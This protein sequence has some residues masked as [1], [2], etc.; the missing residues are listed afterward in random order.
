MSTVSSIS[1]L[2]FYAAI[3]IPFVVGGFASP[4]PFV[5]GFRFVDAHSASRMSFGVN[6]VGRF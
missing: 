1:N 6:I 4:L 2:N 3:A 5:A